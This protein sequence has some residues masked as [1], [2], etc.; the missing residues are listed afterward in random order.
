MTFPRPDAAPP[1]PPAEIPLRTFTYK[2][3]GG[4][5]KT[6]EAHYIQF[7]AQHVTFW[8]EK[9]GGWDYLVLAEA[10]RDCLEVKETT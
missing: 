9:P 3:W 7:T 1:T 10:A 6:V 4:K 5:P 8:L 2:T